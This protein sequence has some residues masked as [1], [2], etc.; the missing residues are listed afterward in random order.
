MC[1]S[2]KCGSKEGGCVCVC[3]HVRVC[4]CVCV[5]VGV[6]VGVCVCVCVG[7]CVG[8]KYGGGWLREGLWKK[9]HSTTTISNRSGGKL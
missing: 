5:C 8:V 2:L 3:K 9:L 4:V 6:C 7:V 1:L